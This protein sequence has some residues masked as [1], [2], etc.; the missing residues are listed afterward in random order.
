VDS[1]N[2]LDSLDRG[3]VCVVTG[4]QGTDGHGN[5]VTLGR[6]GSD[7]SAVAL[8]IAVGASRC[9]F[10]KDVD[11]IYTADPRLVP[12]AWKVDEITSEEMLELTSTGAKVLQMRS[13]ELAMKH[14]LAVSVRSSFHDVP[15]TLIKP[16]QENMEEPVVSGLSH[17]MGQAKVGIHGLPGTPDSLSQALAPL[18]ADDISVDFVTQNVGVDGRMSVAFTLDAK[19]VELALESLQ[20]R[21]SDGPKGQVEIKVERDLAK[22][23]AVGIGMRTHAGVAYRFFSCLTAEGIPIHMALSTEIK[24]SCLVPAKDCPR[25]VQALHREFFEGTESD[26]QSP[27]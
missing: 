24:V 16:M 22:V 3:V 1:A 18:A 14:H 4:F 2:L 5:I 17:D 15:G 21:L 9:E 11:G 20:R 13:V 27:N 10:Y 23:T 7:T 25:A 6:G 26:P 8:A 12:A 19:L